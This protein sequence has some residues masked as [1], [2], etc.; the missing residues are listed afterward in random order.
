[1]NGVTYLDI[2]SEYCPIDKEHRVMAETGFQHICRKNAT[3]LA[4]TPLF[5]IKDFIF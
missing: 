4:A 2:E 5:F 1:V 3:Y